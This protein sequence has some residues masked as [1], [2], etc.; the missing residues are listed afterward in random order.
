MMRLE[1]L[2]LEDHNDRHHGDHHS[3]H[4]GYAAPNRGTRPNPRGHESRA[5]VGPSD[6]TMATPNVVGLWQGMVAH[7]TEKYSD[8]F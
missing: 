6:F 7:E 2:P 1:S 5:R 4:D 8:T 3:G